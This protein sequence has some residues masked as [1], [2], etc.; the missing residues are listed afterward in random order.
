MDIDTHLWDFVYVKQTNKKTSC[1]KMKCA[2]Y[3]Y[4]DLLMFTRLNVYIRLK[5]SVPDGC[6]T[7]TGAMVCPVDR[8]QLIERRAVLLR[9]SFSLCKVSC[10]IFHGKIQLMNFQRLVASL[11]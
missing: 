7:N 10:V 9:S 5:I 3:R 2:C 1:P 8:K 11:A 4:L 6:V